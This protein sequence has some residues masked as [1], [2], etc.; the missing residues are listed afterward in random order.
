MATADT[1]TVVTASTRRRMARVEDPTNTAT[2]RGRFQRDANARWRAV[3]GDIR[4]TIERNDA[5]GLRETTPGYSIGYRGHWRGG[6]ASA[7]GSGDPTP[8]LR[9]DTLGAGTARTRPARAQAAFED[10]LDTVLDVRLGLTTP[11]GRQGASEGHAWHAEYIRHAYI[12]GIALANADLRA[13][14]RDID[15]DDDP[16]GSGADDGEERAGTRRVN[17]N[18]NEGTDP[19]DAVNTRQHKRALSQEYLAT[20]TDVKA[21]AGAAS[22]EL[23]RELREQLEASDADA[24]VVSGALTSRVDAVGQ[25]RTSVVANTRVVATTNRAIVEQADLLG[26]EMLGVVPESDPRGERTGAVWATA[27]NPC[28]L[29]ASMEG[30]TA[31]VIDVKR[32][33]VDRPVLDTH[34]NCRCRWIV[35]G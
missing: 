2:L 1:P 13:A 34:P 7:T 15:P 14:G 25:T 28:P 4:E 21:A 9:V 16:R 27:E 24:R 12:R 11:G 20:Q 30:M 22:T 33:D 32:G 19:T 18:A 8:R 35:L 3:R 23:A 31:R 26:A 10:W 29:C 6:A 5:L 17:A